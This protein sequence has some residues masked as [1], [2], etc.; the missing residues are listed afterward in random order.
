MADESK[1][2]LIGPDRTETTHTL[3]VLNSFNADTWYIRPEY[4]SQIDIVGTQS[5]YID[6]SATEKNYLALSND[7]NRQA[8]CTMCSQEWYR[9]VDSELGLIDEDR[10]LRGPRVESGFWQRYEETWGGAQPPASQALLGGLEGFVAEAAV[11]RFVD[12]LGAVNTLRN[13]G[14]L[15]KM[16]DTDAK[17]WTYEFF[18]ETVDRNPYKPNSGFRRSLGTPI[19]TVG[20]K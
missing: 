8:W 19:E 16:R 9:Q 3:N 14:E 15:D 20:C 13:W 17:P 18:M 1:P 5:R 6:S 11:P 7:S 4:E 10:R 2:L 12:R